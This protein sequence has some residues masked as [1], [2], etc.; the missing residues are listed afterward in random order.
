MKYLI[1]LLAFVAAANAGNG[2]AVERFSG[3]VLDQDLVSIDDRNY[4]VVFTS[5]DTLVLETSVI[6]LTPGDSTIM[7]DFPED[8]DMFCPAKSYKC[9]DIKE[10]ISLLCQEGDGTACFAYPTKNS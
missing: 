2:Y 5:S 1:M 9:Y 6:E 3:L 4:A 8:I 7:V 10:G